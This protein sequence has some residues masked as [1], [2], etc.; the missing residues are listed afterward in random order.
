MKKIISLI[1]AVA[2]IAAGVVFL[3]KLI[4]G[5]DECGEFFIGTGYEPNVV[6]DIV[7]D[8]LDP[9]AE[10]KI[11]CKACAEKQHAIAIGLGG[12]VDDYKLPLF[13]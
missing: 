4:H 13:D 2:V 6:S 11:I 10:D 12:S 7:S 3:P 1:V 8:I 9:E 5:C